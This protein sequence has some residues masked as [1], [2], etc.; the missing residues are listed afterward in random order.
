MSNTF[1]K[2]LVVIVFLILWNS[3]GCKQSLQNPPV[4]LDGP[5]KLDRMI[6]LIHKYH[7]SPHGRGERDVINTSMEL[8]RKKILGDEV[9]PY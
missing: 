7:D 4:P 9:I 1:V 3:S 2:F 8:R 6:R 5:N